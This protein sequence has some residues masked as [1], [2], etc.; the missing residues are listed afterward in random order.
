[1]QTGG[2]TNTTKLI[3][4]FHYFAKAPKNAIYITHHLIYALWD[5]TIYLVFTLK[6]FKF[7][8]LSSAKY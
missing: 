2:Q 7:I 6:F 5:P 3:V 8:E 1:M 4:A